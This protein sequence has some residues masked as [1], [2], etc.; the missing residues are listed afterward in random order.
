ME[1]F[2]ESL[3]NINSA[4]NGFIW[5]KI[6]LVM[7]IGTGIITTIITKF[8]YHSIILPVSIP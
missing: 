1:K 4:I 3:T 5:V 7:L 6:G 8:F 2:V